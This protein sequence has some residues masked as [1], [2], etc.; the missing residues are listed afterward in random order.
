MKVLVGKDLQEGTETFRP[1]YNA[2]ISADFC[3]SGLLE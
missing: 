2:A 3:A 1:S